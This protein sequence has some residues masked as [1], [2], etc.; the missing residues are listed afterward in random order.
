M[1]GIIR[2]LGHDRRKRLRTEFLKREEREK[3]DVPLAKIVFPIGPI[4][5]SN[6]E[7]TR[8]VPGDFSKRLCQLIVSRELKR[9][10]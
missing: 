3:D 2:I 7:R 9:A 10:K 4:D 6:R 5:R 1:A 8:R